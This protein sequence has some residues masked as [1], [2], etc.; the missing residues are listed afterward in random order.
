MLPPPMRRVNGEW[1]DAASSRAAMGALEACRAGAARFVGGCVRNSL[2]G[3]PAGDVDIATKLLPGDVMMALG[4]A[5][6]RA[7]PTGIEHGT[8]TAIHD[9]VPVE[10]TTLRRDVETDGR[11]AVVAFTED[12]TEDAARRDFR[13]NAI[14]AEPDGTLVEPIAG[15]IEDAIAGRVVF[16]GDGD[17]RLREDY[18]RI[19]RFYRFNAWYGAGIDTEGQAA[20]A[21]Q[22][23]GLAQIAAE[24][25]WKELKRLLEA[26]DPAV[27]VLAMEEAGVLE[28]VLP[29]ASADGLP[30]LVAVEQAAGL[31]PDPMR[32]MMAMMPRR[33]RE[34]AHV[35][36]ALKMSNAERSRLDA[37]ADPALGHVCEA[38]PSRLAEALYRHGPE[39]VTDR[40]VLDAS[41]GA[42]LDRLGQVLRQV[43]GWRRPA[44]PL[45]GEDALGAGLIGPAI[46]ETLRRLEEDWIASGFVLTRATLLK[47]IRGSNPAP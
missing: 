33:T 3:L 26:P 23:G 30:S 4:A 18:L 34:V 14:Y 15:S 22:H 36:V 17:A 11:R 42:N 7:L 1:L 44:F 8:V 27:A 46:G 45:T 40:A 6:I 19:L 2:R 16:I 21:R 29:G 10:I 35:G 28:A 31:A 24:R 37:W 25:I 5:G 20:C 41:G 12:W 9:G 39:S 47:R 38:D 13:L 32:R 43:T